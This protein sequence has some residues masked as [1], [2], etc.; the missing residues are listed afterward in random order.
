MVPVAS[1]RCFK[2]QKVLGTLPSRKVIA[3]FIAQMPSP[4]SH[5]FLVIFYLPFLSDF[6]F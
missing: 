4:S 6:S 1:D 5:G 2:I 3:K